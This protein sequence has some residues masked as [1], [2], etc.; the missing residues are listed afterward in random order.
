MKIL[1][2]ITLFTIYSFFSSAEIIN[3]VVVNNNKRIT[4]ETVVT[5]GNIQVGTNYDKSDVDQILKNLYD[6]NFFS[7]IR[8]SVENSTLTIFLEE[9]KIIQTIV[10]NGIKAE[11]IKESIL[12]GMRLKNRSPFVEF[13][14][15]I[16][17]F[18]HDYKCKT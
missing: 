1:Y 13:K 18:I 6:T 17:C 16:K 14:V 12:E 10:L 4:K 7:D 9:N 3:N 11:R 15:K 8:I 2:F 5:L